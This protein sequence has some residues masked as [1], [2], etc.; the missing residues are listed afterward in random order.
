MDNNLHSFEH[1]LI[2]NWKITFEFVEHNEFAVH[3]LKY[4]ALGII[5]TFS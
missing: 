2:D 1:K 5:N 4:K 3:L